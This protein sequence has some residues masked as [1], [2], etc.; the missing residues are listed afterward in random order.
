MPWVRIDDQFPEHPKV[1]QVGPLGMAMQVAA[2]CYS[3]RKLTDGFV[4]RGIARTLLD[5]ELVANDRI[6]TVAVTS[7]MSG[8]DV[9]SDWV[10]D[11]LLD[12]GIWEEV[13]GGYQIHDYHDYQPSKD[14]VEAER[15]AA[16][17]RMADV[18]AKRKR[19]SSDVRANSSGS[20]GSPVP[21]PSVLSEQ[22]GA[23]KRD[24]ERPAPQPPVYEG[25]AEVTARPP[26]PEERAAILRALGRQVDV[27]DEQGAA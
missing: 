9:T 2:L 5:W 12:A 15:A 8:D 27:D 14:D 24:A 22:K 3:N 20:S 23:R 4:P 21:V 18:R 16:R 7:G 6:Y 1:A 17:Q 19:S 11:L 25:S 26:S 13:P 10:I